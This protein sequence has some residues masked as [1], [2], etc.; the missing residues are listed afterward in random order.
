MGFKIKDYY[1]LLGKRA[2][3]NLFKGNQLKKKRCYIKK[4]YNFCNW[5]QS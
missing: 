3:Q 2:S 1:K 4:K 5:N